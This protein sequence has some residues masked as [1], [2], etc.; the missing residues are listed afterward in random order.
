MKIRH[1]RH[2]GVRRLFLEDDARGVPSASVEKITK[3]LWFLRS[4]ARPDELHQY[5]GW[6]PHRMKGQAKGVE[7]WS[8]RVTGNWRLVFRVDGDEIIDI[9][10][11]DYH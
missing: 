10:F 8:L 4:M 5:P 11:K 1:I 7:R 9:D 3:M 2:S 6:R